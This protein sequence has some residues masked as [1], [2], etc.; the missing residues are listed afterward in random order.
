[1]DGKLVDNFLSWLVKVEYFSS[2][3]LI[4]E[5]RRLPILDSRIRTPTSND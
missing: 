4:Y 3:I 1:M 5:R 2:E